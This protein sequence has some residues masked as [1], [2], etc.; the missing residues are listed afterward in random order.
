MCGL[1]SIVLHFKRRIWVKFQ[2]TLIS[3]ESMASKGTT[4]KLY[5]K[6]TESTGNISRCRLC[7]SVTDSKY[8]RN[9]FRDCSK[10]NA[11]RIYGRELLYSESL[12]HLIC[13]PCERRLNNAIKFR[14][15]IEETQRA[16]QENV[17]SKRCVDVS[18]SVAKPPRKISS[19]GTSRHCSIDFN[20]GSGESESNSVLSPLNVSLLQSNFHNLNIVNLNIY[21]GIFSVVNKMLKY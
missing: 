12:P 3:I 13:A 6:Q 20:I 4:K 17:R 1:S 21:F 5:Q 8:S 16:L 19:I 14:D 2:T 7:N 10:V 15:V 11:E 9:L 18:P